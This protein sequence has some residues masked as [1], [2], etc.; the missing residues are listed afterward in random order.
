MS[1]ISENMSDDKLI[2]IHINCH[3]DQVLTIFLAFSVLKRDYLS[4]HPPPY[5]HHT[6]V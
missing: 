5:M 4:S 3:L 2:L 1:L 6:S